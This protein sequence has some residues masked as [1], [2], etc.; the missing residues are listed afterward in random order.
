MQAANASANAAL[1][2]RSVAR[3]VSQRASVAAG[4]AH[5]SST[6]I[7]EYDSAGAAI[8]P[9]AANSAQPGVTTRRASR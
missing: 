9:T 6:R 5:G 7:G 3:T 8:V 2:G 4:Y 1:V